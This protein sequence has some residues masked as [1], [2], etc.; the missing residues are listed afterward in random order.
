MLTMVKTAIKIRNK[1]GLSSARPVKYKLIERKNGLRE[2][3]KIPDVTSS[4]W[5]FSSKPKRSESLK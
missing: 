1:Q 4:P 5:L 3:M 2:N